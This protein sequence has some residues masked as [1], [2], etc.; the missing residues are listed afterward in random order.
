MSGLR[1]GPSGAVVNTIDMHSH[2]F[3]REWEDLSARF[4]GEW[5]WMKHLD[6]DKAMVMVGDREFRP[7][8]SACWNADRRL[9]EM[10]RDGVDLQV[11]CSTPVLFAYGRPAAQA[12][13]CA[14]LFND[15]GLELAARGKGRLK[16]L[17]Q[18]P[19]QDTD[20]RVQGALAR[21]ARRPPRRADRQ[22]CR[23]PRPRRRGH[24]RLPAALRGG[25]R[26]GAGASL[27]H[28]GRGTH[29]ALDDGL[30]R[31]HAGGDA[32]V[33]RRA[34]PRRRLR[35]PA[36]QPAHLLRAR[37]RQLRVP[38]RTA[39]KR[40]A[41]P[42]SRARQ[43]R[44]PARAITWTASTSTARCSTRARCGCWSRSW[45][46]TASCSAR[47][48]RFR[49]ASSVSASWCAT[50]RASAMARALNCWPATHAVFWGWHEKQDQDRSAAHRARRRMAVRG[51]P[52]ARHVRAAA[53]RA[54]AARRGR[55]VRDPER[56]R[57]HA[58]CRRSAR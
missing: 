39:G 9:E 5:P 6:A 36:G 15:A 42:R 12:L 47:T 16:T 21:D 48:I 35:P 54:R 23:R 33:H 20:A 17:C 31:V 55:G 50:C 46:R 37:R 8:Y 4:G 18:V 40:L 41:Q 28:D 26:R 14:Q 29:R 44:P 56:V 49:S 1:P 10:D 7:V 32:A 43:V 3:P 53:G 24:R 25:R 52:R 30:D 27:G 11:M 38:A 51:A 45:A 13:Y 58:R 34:D 19:L 22:S 57:R 2:F